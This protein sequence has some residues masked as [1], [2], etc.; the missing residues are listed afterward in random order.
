[1]SARARA[2]GPILLLIAGRDMTVAA[3]CS[4]SPV[5][6]GVVSF[7]RRS[8]LTR[9]TH[10]HTLTRTHVYALSRWDRAR[11]PRTERQAEATY[12]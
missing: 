8:R 3:V 9:F 10:M 2:E 11:V 7:D 12:K 6:S 4:V 5:G 1:M